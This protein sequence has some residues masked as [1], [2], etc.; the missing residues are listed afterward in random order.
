MRRHTG[1]SGQNP[2]RLFGGRTL[3]R[4]AGEVYAAVTHAAVVSRPPGALRSPQPKSV[5]DRPERAM[6]EENIHA[7][8]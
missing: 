4:Q 5:K 2:L 1:H 8:A 6:Q 7:V 3:T